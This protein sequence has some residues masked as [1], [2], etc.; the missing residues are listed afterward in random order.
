[1]EKETAEKAQSIMN[2]IECMKNKQELLKSST[3]ELC[4][5]DHFTG[6]GISANSRYNDGI[7]EILSRHHSAIIE[8]L[9]AGI[10]QLEDEL[11]KL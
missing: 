10:R 11:R 3:C 1:M 9:K 8:E 2:K 7:G 6:N 4:F 5:V